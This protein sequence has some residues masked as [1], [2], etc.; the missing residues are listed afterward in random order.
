MNCLSLVECFVFVFLFFFFCWWS[1]T[2][3]HL[4]VSLTLKWFVLY[5]PELLHIARS[6]LFCVCKLTAVHLRCLF[7]RS[8]TSGVV[9]PVL[10]ELCLFWVITV[11]RC[12]PRMIMWFIFTSRSNQWLLETLTSVRCLFFFW[13]GRQHNQTL[14]ANPVEWTFCCQVDQLNHFTY[15]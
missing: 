3:Q 5:W 13:G 1:M 11:Q 4:I 9:Q 12:V 7:L 15:I 14:I 10:E 8:W 2:S 6:R